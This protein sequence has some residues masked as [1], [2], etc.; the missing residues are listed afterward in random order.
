[1][2]LKLYGYY[3]VINKY[4]NKFLITLTKYVLV[5]YGMNLQRYSSADGV[6]I[7]RLRMIKIYLLQC[8]LAD[9]FD[10]TGYAFNYI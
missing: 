10:V 2:V 7:L 9:A 6:C 8:S 1:M 4:L 3:H 5:L